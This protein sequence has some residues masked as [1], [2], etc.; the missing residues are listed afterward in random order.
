MQN[1]ENWWETVTPQGGGWPKEHRVL[2][3]RKE[4]SG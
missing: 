1:L 3:V 2:A 4:G